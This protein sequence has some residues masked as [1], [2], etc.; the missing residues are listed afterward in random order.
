[1]FFHHED[2]AADVEGR[3]TMRKDELSTALRNH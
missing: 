2:P 1:M 3:S